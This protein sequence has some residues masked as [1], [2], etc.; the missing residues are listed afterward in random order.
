MNGYIFKGSNST[1][2]IFD[3]LLNGSQL[4]KGFFLCVCV[5]GG[6]GGR[7]GGAF[8][9]GQI[10]SFNRR[11]RE[12]RNISV[13]GVRFPLHSCQRC[14]RAFLAGQILSF[15]RRPREDRNIS[16]VGVR[17]PLHSCQRCENLL[18]L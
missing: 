9:A 16:V 14:E 13:V 1:I 11:P 2:F 8:L 18:T 15:N 17:F 3:S 5:G 4:S 6:G 12:D 10:L 7:G